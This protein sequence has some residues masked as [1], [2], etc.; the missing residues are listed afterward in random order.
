MFG[1]MVNSFYYGKSGKGDFRK[2]DL[3]QNRWQLF[4]EMLRVRI[5]GLCRLNLMTVAAWLPLLIVIINLISSVFNALVISTEF[6]NY[7]AYGTLTETFTQEMAD[8]LAAEGIVDSATMN[9]MFVGVL[10]TGLQNALLWMIPC[11][12]ITGP[13]QAG[14]SYVT[15][16]WA[17]DEHAFIWS[18]FK[19]AVIR[20][21]K[22]A[23]GVSAITSVVPFLMY[24]CFRFYGNMANDNMLFIVP[25]MLTLSLGLV[26]FLGLTFMYPL[27]VTYTYNFRTLIKNSLLLAIAR[28][29]HTIVMRL[30]AMLPALIC[31]LIS[32]M[33]AGNISIYALLALLAYYV[34]LGFAMSRF[35]FASYTNG[36][37]D[38]YLNSRIEG[39]QI[40]RGMATESDEDEEDEE[41]QPEEADNEE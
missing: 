21:W 17:R 20:N 19:D 37:F 33:T 36:I 1:K 35:I 5:S 10:I 30:A 3:P 16:N 34:L 11:I 12:L 2:E 8:Q 27:M 32:F 38:K 28:L 9:N 41:E 18:D 13:V 14:L 4:W 29:P 31:L 6:E 15:R 40:N 39:V 22:Q 25:Q 24:M 7:L 26:W 23:L